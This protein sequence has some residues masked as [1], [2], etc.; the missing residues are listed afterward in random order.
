MS[1][2]TTSPITQT[3]TTEE[4][5][6]E[7]DAITRFIQMA[8]P[9]DPIS[10]VNLYVSLKSKPMAIL[11]GAAHSGKS[12]VVRCLAQYLTDGDPIRSQMMNGHAWWAE[13]TRDIAFFIETQTRFNTVKLLAVIEEAWQP[14]NTNSVFVACL[15]RISPAEVI[16]FFS[17]L[18][19][20]LQHGQIMRLP[21]AR[22]TEPIPYPPNLFLIGTMDTTRFDWS[23]DENLLS[24]TTMIQWSEGEMKPTTQRK[25]ESITLGET[26]FLR[27]LIR[28]EAVARLK[29]HH[30]LGNEQP[31]LH[32]LLLAERLLNE[33]E[34][35]LPGS[36]KGETLVYV[37]NAWSKDGVGLFD[38]VTPNNLATALD[39]AIVQILLPR[40]SA[41]IRDSQTL[42]RRLQEALSQFPSS[43]EVLESLY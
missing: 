40:I 41:I 35:R 36:V 7:C 20:Q 42:R 19:F 33:Q 3:H 10:I 21:R 27:S 13:K 8:S 11:T 29:L 4:L 12:E 14:E 43:V 37:A 23:D 30:I 18:A 16:S 5:V 32:P 31:A 2:L 38:Q 17:D 34:I 24:K 9:V 15:T 26:G 6:T 39:L 1:V 25:W 28:D 22:L